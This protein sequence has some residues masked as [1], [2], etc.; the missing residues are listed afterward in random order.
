MMNLVGDAMPLSTSRLKTGSILLAGV[1]WLVEVGVLEAEGDG[2][3]DDRLGDFAGE[4]GVFAGKE[5]GKF[6]N[7]NGGKDG[8]DRLGMGRKPGIVPH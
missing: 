1:G 4:G 3:G 5:E 2:G 6:P 8:M 7:T